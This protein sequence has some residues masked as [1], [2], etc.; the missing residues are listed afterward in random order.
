MTRGLQATEKCLDFILLK[1][2]GVGE[3]CD[4]IQGTV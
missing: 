4:R 1:F 3:A 2:E